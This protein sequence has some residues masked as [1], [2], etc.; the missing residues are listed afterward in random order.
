MVFRPFYISQNNYKSIHCLFLRERR[1]IEQS[2]PTKVYKVSFS[3]GIS[4]IIGIL[5]SLKGEK[6]HYTVPFEQFFRSGF[7]D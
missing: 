7:R 3:I 2:D 6:F 4:V 1:A 5:D